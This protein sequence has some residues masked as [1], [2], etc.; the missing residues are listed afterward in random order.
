MLDIFWH[1]TK[2]GQ[3]LV[4]RIVNQHQEFVLLEKE[5]NQLQTPQFR[6]GARYVFND[7][8]MESLNV[9]HTRTFILQI[10]I[11]E[12]KMFFFAGDRCGG[13]AEGEQVAPRG[14]RDHRAVPVSAAAPISTGWHAHYI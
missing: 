11:K 10:A 12:V 14:L 6:I 4:D 8:A 1:G 9:G 3:K 5:Q 7:L 13:R 2:V